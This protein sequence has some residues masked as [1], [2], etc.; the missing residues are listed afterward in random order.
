MDLKTTITTSPNGVITAN[1]P[2][3]YDWVVVNN[4]RYDHIDDIRYYGGYIT[5]AP[6]GYIYG[7]DLKVSNSN[8]VL[9]VDIRSNAGGTLEGT[10]VDNFLNEVVEV[11][12]RYGYATIYVDGEAAGSVRFDLNFYIDIDAYVRY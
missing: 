4:G 3:G 10:Q 1:L 9:P 2:I 12:R 8:I 7:F 6:N 11:V 5:V